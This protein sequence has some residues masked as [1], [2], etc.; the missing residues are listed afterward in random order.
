MRRSCMGTRDGSHAR[1]PSLMQT[2]P[3]LARPRRVDA[4]SPS[5]ART[6][7]RSDMTKK[8]K[9]KPILSE[10]SK[11]DTTT[12]RLSL[13]RREYHWS[14]EVT[15]IRFRAWGAH[16]FVTRTHTRRTNY[17]PAFP[18]SYP[19]PC[20]PPS[21]CSSSA[22]SSRSP[23]APR[24]ASS[25]SSSSGSTG[26][27]ATTAT[28]V[29]PAAWPPPSPAAGPATPRATAATAAAAASTTATC[30][31]WTPTTTATIPRTG[32]TPRAGAGSPGGVS[33]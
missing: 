21:S 23:P 10:T 16:A 20:V 17:L 18:T 14:N 25:A 8:T 28:T 19:R 5:C 6:S 33:T 12:T 24:P 7:S 13:G 32:G 22:S 3:S 1:T 27:R 29:A 2:R 30:P 9:I 11:G 15:R 26:A 31:T 4:H